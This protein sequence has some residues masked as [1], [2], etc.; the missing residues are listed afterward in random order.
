MKITDIKIIK[1]YLKPLTF[2]NKNSLN[3][4]DN[5]YYDSKN[6]FIFSFKRRMSF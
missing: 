4:V 2:N 1:K 3:L 5:V 6:K